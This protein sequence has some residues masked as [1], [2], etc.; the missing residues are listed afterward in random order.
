MNKKYPFKFLD[1]YQKEDKDFFFGRK[2]EVNELYKM[3]FKTKIMLIYG[4]S[5]TGKT[6]LIQCGLANKFKTYDWLS[7]FI[8]RG[9]D[10]IGSLDRALCN[11]IDE[12]FNSEDQENFTITNLEEKIKKVYKGSF[13]PIYLIFDQFEELYVIGSKEEQRGFIKIIKEIL[14][15]DLPVTVIISIREEYL[16][17]LYEFEKEVPQLLR[18]KLRVESMDKL[19]VRDVTN[20]INAYQ[21]SLVKIKQDQIDD[22]TDE[23]FERVKGEEN[24]RTIQLPFL[25]V[26]LDKLYMNSTGDES[27]NTEAL[28][29]MEDLDEIGDIGDVMQDFLESQVEEINKEL[30]EKYDVTE[31][32]VWSILSNFCTLEGTKEPISKKDLALRLHSTLDEKLVYESVDAFAKSRILRDIEDDDLYELW[33]DSLALKIVE[34]RSADDIKKLEIKR[35]I[36]SNAGLRVKANSL[37]NEDELIYIGPYEDKIDSELTPDEKKFL[38][39]SKVEIKRKKNE[40]NLKKRRWRY[41]YYFLSSS[42]IIFLLIMGYNGQKKLEKSRATQDFTELELLISNAQI[43]IDSAGI[44]REN[45]PTKSIQHFW[46]ASK[47]LQHMDSTVIMDSLKGK[48]YG[49]YHNYSGWLDVFINKEYWKIDSIIKSRNTNIDLLSKSILD[50]D[51]ALYKIAIPEN[52]YDSA[53]TFKPYYSNVVFPNSHESKGFKVWRVLDEKVKNKLDT[54]DPN[55]IFQVVFPKDTNEMMILYN[56][57]IAEYLGSNKYYKK[58]ELDRNDKINSIA[59]IEYEVIGYKMLSAMNRERIIEWSLNGKIRHNNEVEKTDKVVYKKRDNDFKDRVISI[60]ISQDRSRIFTASDKGIGIVWETD[61]S[62]IKMKKEAQRLEQFNLLQDTI[63]CSAFSNNGVY[64]ASGSVDHTV[65]IWNSATRKLYKIFRGHSAAVTS[66]AF[67]ANDRYLYT[68]SMD[69]TF[70]KWKLP[71]ENDQIGWNSVK[72][73]DYMI[74]EGLIDRPKLPFQIIKKDSL[75]SGG[76]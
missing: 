8:R 59:P 32:T 55:K 67:S 10:L 5:G 53:S 48:D 49:F 65:K 21:D 11:E 35:F 3:I 64:V 44:H 37:L 75:D 28:L 29:S 76:K 15:L 46:K 1:S 33:H 69:G 60:A 66:V 18:K 43:A 63:K 16:G 47:L 36:K 52:D 51:P 30:N 6:S 26:F 40:K 41:A 17:Y 71:E 56:N 27:H 2:E 23:I 38:K 72:N 31:D 22:I 4:T 50:T 57:G 20:G 68:G 13:R 9:G 12:P 19:K 25:Q 58:L 39:D 70:R 62:N 74:E 34:K 7:L 45:D 14:S 73:I 54:I 61:V 24:S 42:A